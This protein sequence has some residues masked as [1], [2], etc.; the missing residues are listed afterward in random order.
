MSM[1]KLIKAF[2]V[3]KAFDYFR[4]RQRSRARY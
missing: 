1:K 2:A 3:K 4:G